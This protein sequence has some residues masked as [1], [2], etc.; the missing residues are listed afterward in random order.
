MY[1]ANLDFADRGPGFLWVTADR[2]DRDLA[3]KVSRVGRGGPQTADR[4]NL[5]FADRGPRYLRGNADRGAG[6]GDCVLAG[7]VFHGAVDRGPR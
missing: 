3:G 6:S 1:R 7:K 2:G 4:T 5:D